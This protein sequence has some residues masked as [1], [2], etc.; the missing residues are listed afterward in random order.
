MEWSSKKPPT[1]FCG[2]PWTRAACAPDGS[3]AR[4]WRLDAVKLFTKS[5]LGTAPPASCAAMSA[6][7]SP[8]VEARLTYD[9]S[10]AQAPATAAAPR[11]QQPGEGKLTLR[12]KLN[13][14]K[15]RMKEVS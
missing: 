14:I 3:A 4:S 7:A 11:N 12:A 1:T 15:L 9:N 13:A 5:S 2:C 8:L 6:A 10:L